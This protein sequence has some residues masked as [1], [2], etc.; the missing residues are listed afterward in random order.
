MSELNFVTLLIIW[1]DIKIVMVNICL[2][3]IDVI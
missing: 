3:D 1:I 2:N